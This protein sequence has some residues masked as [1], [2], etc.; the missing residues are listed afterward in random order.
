M[1]EISIKNY[2]KIKRMLDD[3]VNFKMIVNHSK[4]PE[5]IIK[6]FIK[7]LEIKDIMPMKKDGYE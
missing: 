6:L 3:G 2:Y 5:N 4:T 7:K 1:E